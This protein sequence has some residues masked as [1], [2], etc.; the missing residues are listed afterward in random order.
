MNLAAEDGGGREILVDARHEMDAM[1]V[2]QAAH[3]R[4]RQVVAAQRRTFV[5][6]MK[7]AVFRPARRSRRIWSMGR[8][9]S[10]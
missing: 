5:S 1:L 10:T 2:E 3:A 6:E 7:A 4:Q 9:T 8:R